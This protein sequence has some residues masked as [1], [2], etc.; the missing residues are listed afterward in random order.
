MKIDND[1]NSSTY[2][3]TL[4]SHLFVPHIIHP[5]RITSTT[6]TII[7][8]I[9]S[10]APNYQKAISGNLTTRLSDHLAQFLI[11]PD[12]CDHD[13]EKKHT[14]IHDLRN[15]DAAKF[16]EE[17]RELPLPDFKANHWSDP[18]HA[19]AVFYTKLKMIIDKHLKRRKVTAKEIKNMQKPWVTKEV[20]KTIKKRDKIHKKYLR[21]VTESKGTEKEK[22]EIEETRS[23][24]KTLRNQITSTIRADKKQWYKDFFTQNADNLRKTWRGIKTIINM[25]NKE[26]LST[27]L[28][29]ADDI[30]SDPKAVAN[31]F[32]S[33]FSTVAEKLQKNIRPRG[34]NFQEYLPPETDNSIFIEPSSMDEVTE[35]INNYIINKKAT[36][37]NSIPAFILQL[38]TPFIAEPLSDI[39]NLSFFKGKYI[40]FLKISRIIAIYKEKGDQLL[41][42]NYRPISL[43]PNIN[44]IF[45]KIMYRRVYKFVEDKNILYDL[46]F[47][48]RMLHSTQH[49]I[50][51]I[52][53]D[54]RSAI[55]DNMFALGIFIDLQKAF[56][57]V[58]HEILLSKLNHYGIRGVAND[59]F[60]SYLSNRQQF[61]RI[62]DAVSDTSYINIGVPQGSVLGPL[63]FLL[64]INDLHFSILHSKT[65]YFADDTCLLLVNESLKKIKNK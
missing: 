49:A 57:T 16:L 38:I 62:D 44:K 4:T 63:L 34:K 18:N 43:L 20:I 23:Q 30:S 51:D 33:Y 12:D 56:D 54:I 61:V 5:T 6:K 32:N 19:F 41:A 46:Q 40:D 11:I 15:F 31:E 2:F 52:T 35:I 45:E 27:S 25:K 59:W 64:Y 21:Q 39:I 50:A 42:K 14:Y 22:V 36:G 13:S 29:I 24:Y 26:S 55:D 65:R 37:P 1:S 9:F 60:R 53:E 7:D 17:I 47:G 8:N 28:L 10:N 58:D 48:F 3:D